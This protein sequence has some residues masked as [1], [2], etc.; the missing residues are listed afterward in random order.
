MTVH[1]PNTMVEGSLEVVVD[2]ERIDVGSGMII[3]PQL[4]GRACSLQLDIGAG[5]RSV[6]VLHLPDVGW[7]SDGTQGIPGPPSLRIVGYSHGGVVLTWGWVE[8]VPDTFLGS[9]LKLP[10]LLGLF[11]LRVHVG[12]I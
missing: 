10:W 5:Q 12:G 1:T 2:V 11:S 8:E 6:G 3:F 4:V 7:H 9:S